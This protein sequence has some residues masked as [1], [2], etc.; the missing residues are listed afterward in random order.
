M[1]YSAGTPSSSL[2]AVAR[3][4]ASRNLSLGRSTANSSSFA[5]PPFSCSTTLPLTYRTQPIEAFPSAESPTNLPVTL[6]QVVAK[7]TLL[8]LARF[9][10]V[11]VR[12]CCS[13]SATTTASTSTGRPC[14][15]PRRRGR[16]RDTR[17]TAPPQATLR[18]PRTLPSRSGSTKPKFG[19]LWRRPPKL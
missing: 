13:T 14:L 16:T 17:L 10:L 9:S 3:E 6:R 18:R 7:R 2:P 4:H 19:E 5:C 11:S 8:F 1:F 15:R 12:L